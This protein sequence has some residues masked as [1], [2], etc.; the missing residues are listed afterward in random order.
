MGYRSD[1]VALIYPSGGEDNLLNY[2]KLKTLMNTTFKD[3]LDSWGDYF[4][5]NDRH[6]ALKFTAESIK[7]YDSYPDVVRFNEFLT[8]VHVL[9]YEYEIIRIGEDD[10]DIQHDQSGDAQGFLYVT[11][12]I[13]VSF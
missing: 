12:S 5:W 10:T 11:R 6:R 1:V 9:D 2:D 3:V 4:E 7:W 13:E 8:Q